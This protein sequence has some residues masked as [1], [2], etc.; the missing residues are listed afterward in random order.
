M[1]IKLTLFKP[2]Q[3]EVL[4]LRKENKLLIE[5]LEK[6]VTQFEG[7]AGYGNVKDNEAIRE[8]K[9]LLRNLKK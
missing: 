5:A 9:E 4:K 7:I 8:A 3:Q 2:L 1:A 6:C